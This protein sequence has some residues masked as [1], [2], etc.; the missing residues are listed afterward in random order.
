MIQIGTQRFYIIFFLY[1][2]RCESEVQP[3]CHLKAKELA[4][5][6]VENDKNNNSND[7]DDDD[8]E[9]KK[10]RQVRGIE[11]TWW[12]ERCIQ[13]ISSCMSNEQWATVFFFFFNEQTL[14]RWYFEATVNND[15]NKDRNFSKVYHRNR[16]ISNRVRWKS[17]LFIIDAT[18]QMRNIIVIIIER[19]KIFFYSNWKYR[20][21]M[22]FN[23][24]KYFSKRRKNL[25]FEFWIYKIWFFIP[26]TIRSNAKRYRKR[27]RA[28]K[29]RT[30][31]S[32]NCIE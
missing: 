32:P 19:Q 17:I 31:K 13:A 3:K 10:R 26:I 2:H 20:T 23:I 22:L 29:T 16:V 28:I 25:N 30:S 1:P 21:R 8:S 27:Q 14:R 7:E 12:N 24:R 4:A 15:I 6:W 5:F 9:W 18:F 11:S